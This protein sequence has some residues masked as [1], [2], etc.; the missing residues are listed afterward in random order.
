MHCTGSFRLP[1][2]NSILVEFDESDAVMAH[3]CDQSIIMSTGFTQCK[4]YDEF[5]TLFNSIV[6]DKDI[7]PTF[8][9]V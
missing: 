7:N 9:V 2:P 8:N 3:T 4:D 1:L 5:K 6:V